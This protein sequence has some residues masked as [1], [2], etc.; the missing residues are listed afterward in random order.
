MEIIHKIWMPSLIT[1]IDL[2]SRLECERNT[3]DMKRKLIYHLNLVTVSESCESQLI[4]V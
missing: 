4:L 3:K 2:N 1:S